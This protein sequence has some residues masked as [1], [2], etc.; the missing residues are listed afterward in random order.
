MGLGVVGAS[1]TAPACHSRWMPPAGTFC[2]ASHFRI[3]GS[4]APRPGP[5]PRPSLMVLRASPVMRATAPPREGASPA[6]PTAS[7]MARASPPSTKSVV[8][9]TSTFPSAAGLSIKQSA[10]ATRAPQA[11]NPPRRR[12]AAEPRVWE[13][14]TKIDPKSA[15]LISQLHCPTSS[16]NMTTSAGHQ[17]KL[18]DA[19]TARQSKN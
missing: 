3:S 11:T 19:I 15:P 8:R 7:R 13:S 17:E 6:R 4:S 2:A 16:I 1:L 18:P 14:T 10:L 9:N 12:E 5:Q